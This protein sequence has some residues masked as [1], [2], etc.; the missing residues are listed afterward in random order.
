MSRYKTHKFLLVTALTTSLFFSCTEADNEI[1]K[2]FEGTT[3]GAVLRTIN[4]VSNELPTDNIADAS[5]TFAVDL[6]I[7]DEQN[8]DLT[9]SVEV[10]VRFRDNT[11][12]D[13][14]TDASKPEVLLSTI[15]SSSFTQGPL[16]PRLSYS[17]GITEILSALSLTE[18]DVA[19]G[20]DF[21]FRFELVLTDGRRFS[22]AQNSATITGSFFSS[23]FQYTASIVCSETP[24]IPGTWTID[25]EDSFG[26]GWNGAAVIA[27]IDGV[28][29]GPFTFD[30]G[31]SGSFTFEVPVG[32]EDLDILFVSG[33]FDSEVS[34]EITSS[35]GNLKGEF[36]SPA[37][38][39]PL[40][41]NYC[42]D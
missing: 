7:Q 10:Y 21:V 31:S 23:P 5:A 19:G 34:F 36:S 32:A 38:G 18:G 15:A 22:V 9:E 11:I 28:E 17:A 1:D 25:G 29:Q 26:D 2:V 3:R 37:A 4:V 35:A 30:S 24:P 40:P 20:D 27:S 41:L 8:G 12:A 6:E 16:L 33:D 39:T 14:G 13:G 42:V